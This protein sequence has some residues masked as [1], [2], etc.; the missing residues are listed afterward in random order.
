MAL[1]GKI[2][3]RKTWLG[4]LA[5]LVEEDV[6]ARFGRKLKRRWRR[7]TAMDL[8]QPELR[9]LVDMRSR[10]YIGGYTAVPQLQSEPASGRGSF[11]ARSAEANGADRASV[12]L[13]H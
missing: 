9:I 2:D 8:A 5:L 7:A 11:S 6:K 1:T 12:Q 3:F 4:G 10:A 13:P